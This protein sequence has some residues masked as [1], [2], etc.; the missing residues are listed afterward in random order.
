[1]VRKITSDP[2][3][4][5]FSRDYIRKKFITTLGTGFDYIREDAN[6]ERLSPTLLTCSDEELKSILRKV[7]MNKSSNSTVNVSTVSAYGYSSL[8]ANAVHA[9]KPPT[10]ALTSDRTPADPRKLRK[11]SPTG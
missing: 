10:S 8:H 9:V 2:N 5:P 4:P 6:N 1:L 7:H 11:R 3:A